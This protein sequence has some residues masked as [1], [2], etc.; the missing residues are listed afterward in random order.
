LPQR[1]FLGAGDQFAP[2]PLAP[3]SGSHNQPANFGSGFR[4]QVV[5]NRDMDPASHF[6]IDSRN[7]NRVIR[8]ARKGVNSLLHRIQWRRVTQFSAQL[9]DFFCISRVSFT[10]DETV[11]TN[12]NIVTSETVRSRR[13]RSGKPR[14]ERLTWRPFPA[15][16]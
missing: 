12:Q 8:E 5:N 3:N 1:P 16:S 4:L 10:N 15:S 14:L 11:H 6:S 13:S 2:D 7:K 9:A